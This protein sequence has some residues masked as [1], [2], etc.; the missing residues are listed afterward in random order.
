MGRFWFRL[1]CPFCT[2]ISSSLSSLCRKK[3]KKVYWIFLFWIDE[4]IEMSLR[5]S[6]TLKV[7]ASW[8]NKQIKRMLCIQFVFAIIF[9]HHTVDDCCRMPRDREGKRGSKGRGVVFLFICYQTSECLSKQFV[10]IFF[11]ELAKATGKN[12]NGNKCATT[13]TAHIWMP[14]TCD[15]NSNGIQHESNGNSF[16]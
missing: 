8:W 6:V 9:F 5:S 2:F 3:E 7:T 11:S 4:C 13:F 1:T 10:W 16:V 15:S 14:E 12:G